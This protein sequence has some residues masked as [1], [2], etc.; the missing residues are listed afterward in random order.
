MMEPFILTFV[1][2]VVSI[3]IVLIGL[4]LF[5]NLTR[6]YKD[7]EEVKMEILLYPC[8]SLVKSLGFALSYRLPFTTVV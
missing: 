7:M 6:K 1:Y 8:L 3:V 2:F 4:F 5:E